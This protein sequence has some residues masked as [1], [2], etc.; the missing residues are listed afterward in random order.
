MKNRFLI[1]LIFLLSGLFFLLKA[2]I[3]NYFSIFLFLVGILFLI[4]YITLKTYGFLVIGGIA[5][6]LGLALLFQYKSKTLFFIFSGL[7]FLLIYI[8][9]FLKKKSPKWP[10]LPA[11]FLIGIGIY[12]ELQRAGLIPYGIFK[13]I[14]K[15]WPV[16][17]IIIG[18]YLIFKKK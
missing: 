4:L 15:Y 17:L 6:G 16:I 13:E 3:S 14:L 8:L 9:G 5:S 2:H 7:G 11:C 10:L 1:G 18:L 12:E